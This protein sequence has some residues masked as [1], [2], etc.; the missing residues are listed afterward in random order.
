M[1]RRAQLLQFRQRHQHKDRDQRLH[2]SHQIFHV[3]PKRDLAII[4][5]PHRQVVHVL[6]CRVQVAVEIIHLCQPMGDQVVHDHQDLVRQFA[7][8]NLER[9]LVLDND[10]DQFPVV[11]HSRPAM[12]ELVEVARMPG[13]EVDQAEAVLLVEQVD[14]QAADQVAQADQVVAQEAL[15]VLAVL[16]VVAVKLAVNL[17]ANKNHER[18]VAKRSITYAHQLLVAQLFREAMARL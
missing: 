7:Q 18:L 12:A 3:H 17:I 5:S 4:P 11:D 14:L 6:R 8:A 1:R 10:L 9:V 16:L 13:E 2:P 15:P